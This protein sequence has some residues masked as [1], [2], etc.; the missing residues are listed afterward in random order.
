M[1]L[2]L[3]SMCSPWTLWMWRMDEGRFHMTP[4]SPSQ[5]PSVVCPK[6]FCLYLDTI[7]QVVYVANMTTEAV[8]PG[9]LACMIVDLCMIL[10]LYSELVQLH[11]GLLKV[12]FKITT[13]GERSGWAQPIIM[14]A[15]W[16][17]TLTQQC[18][19]CLDLSEINCCRSPLSGLQ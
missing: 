5:V 16:A 6:W 17:G 9:Y 4:V 3:P 2:F 14:V 13:R 18:C 11:K 1:R 15:F 12:L 7:S 8:V 10:L 19:W